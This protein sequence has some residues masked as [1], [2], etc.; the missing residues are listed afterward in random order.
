MKIANF[1]DDFSP[2]L[3]GGIVTVATT[4]TGDA[5]GT[6]G[7]LTVTAVNGVAIP[8]T[9]SAG[10]RLESTSGTAAAWVTMY[11]AG[12][13]AAIGTAGTP[14]T[15]TAAARADHVHTGSQLG[16]VAVSGTAADGR[17]LEADSAS[18]ASWQYPELALTFTPGTA[19]G[20]WAAAGTPLYAPVDGSSTVTRAVLVAT[21]GSPSTGSAYWTLQLQAL[22]AAGSATALGSAVTTAAAGAGTA[23]SYAVTVGTATTGLT[24]AIDAA[25]TGTPGALTLHAAVFYRRT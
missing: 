12:T 5:T 10:A 21:V 3:A 16:A 20:P 11:S 14:G 23:T 24:Y 22:D 9:P 13:P 19:L 2:A 4:V 15:A 25:T 17:V 1:D 7:A 8:G 18:G 6:I